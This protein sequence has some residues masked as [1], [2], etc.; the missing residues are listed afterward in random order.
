V[1]LGLAGLPAFPEERETITASYEQLR[2]GIDSM[3]RMEATRYI[4][5]ALRFD[6]D[7]TFADWRHFG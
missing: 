1:L 2:A 4:D 7:P 3:Y 6:A 5:P